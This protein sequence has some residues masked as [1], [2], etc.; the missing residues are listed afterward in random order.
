MQVAIATDIAYVSPATFPAVAGIL[1]HLIALAPDGEKTDLWL[2][3]RNKMKRVPYNGYL[4]IWLQRVTQ[5]QSV[6][7]KF[8][9]D[10]LIC[11]IVNGGA[12]PLWKCEWISN[13]KLKKSIDVRNLM[14]GDV[15][16]TAEVIDPDEVELFK[17]NAWAY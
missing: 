3:V 13:A 8:E 16:D 9:S 4:E 12:P 17:Q 1:S 6:G 5:P 10:E 2:K 15:T 14:V 7:I 11:Q